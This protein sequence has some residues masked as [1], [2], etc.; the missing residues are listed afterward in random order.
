[1]NTTKSPNFFVKIIKS[2]TDINFYSNF[3]NEKLGKSFGYLLLLALALG[4]I[5][6]GI[7]TLKTN[8]S[9][10][11]SLTFFESEDFPDIMIANGVLDIDIEEPLVLK[12]DGD[13]IFIVD[14]TNTYTL[15]DLAGYSIGYLITP[16]R[17]IINQA[18]SP[19]IPFEFKNLQ[20]FQIDKYT[21]VDFLNKTK[22]VFIGF[23]IFTIIV[24]TILLKLLESLIVSIIALIA[25][26][27][28]N[29]NMSYN[30]LYKISIYALTLPSIIVLII[31]SLSL[32]LSFG[33]LLLIYYSIATIYVVLALK[34]M[35]TDNIEMNH[36]DDLSNY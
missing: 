25:N 24:G 14:M 17:V 1:M 8:K 22:S 27:I 35:D 13:I 33:I 28:L 18:G 30:D 21:A 15:N 2:I 34:N 7:V 5:F 36:Q 26:S 12:Q 6:S 3:R 23:I 32:G 29:K 9:I 16:E 10:D 19:P 20:D 31:N 4:I 11:D